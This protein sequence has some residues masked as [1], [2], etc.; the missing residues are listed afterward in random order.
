MNLNKADN[1]ISIKEEYYNEVANLVANEYTIP[2]E[3]K[4]IDELEGM[5][6]LFIKYSMDNKDYAITIYENGY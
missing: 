1:F 6:I 4:D 5:D 3:E 2:Q